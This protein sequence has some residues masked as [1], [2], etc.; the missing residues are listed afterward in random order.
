MDACTEKAKDGYV[1]HVKNKENTIS[2]VYVV[3]VYLMR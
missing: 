3:E 2:S 1:V